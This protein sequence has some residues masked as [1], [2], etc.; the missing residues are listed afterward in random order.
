MKP[1]WDKLGYEYAGSMSVLIGDVD[2]TAGGQSLCEKQGIQGYPTI[3]YFKDG[4]TEEGTSY[5]GGRDYDSLLQHVKEELEPKCMVAY[6]DDC[7][8]K[9]TEFMKKIEEKTVD[10][11]TK[12]LQ[13]LEG[14][15]DQ[16]MAATNRQWLNQ[17]INLLK[18]F[19]ERKGPEEHDE[20]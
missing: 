3:K 10:E 12:N 14:M 2:C 7:S 1:D 20:L 6:P 15:K 8:E 11:L 9:E 19:I 16:S 5:N 18:Q 13:R 4:D 17:R